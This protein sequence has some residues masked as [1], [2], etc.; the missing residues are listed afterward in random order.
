M[1]LTI[2]K[3]W[4]NHL[5]FENLRLSCI[6]SFPRSKTWIS[7][8]KSELLKFY[9]G[10]LNL[11]RIVSEVYRTFLML[12]FHSSIHLSESVQVVQTDISHGTLSSSHEFGC[13]FF[14]FWK[15][16]FPKEEKGYCFRWPTFP[17]STFDIRNTSLSVWTAHH[18]DIPT[19]GMVVLMVI[20]LRGLGNRSGF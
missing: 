10:D 8:M 13:T 17:G 14:L 19:A 7:L 9:S 15:H 18:F 4:W 16:P 2:A 5:Y 6:V 1:N 20:S 3:L 12:P 11:K